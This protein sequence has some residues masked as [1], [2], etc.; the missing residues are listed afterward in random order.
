MAESIGE[1]VAKALYGV[2]SS[3]NESDSN[4][5]AANV[6]DAIF[7]LGRCA[8]KVAVAITPDD[9]SPGLGATGGRVGS[10]TEAAMDIAG[11]LVRI[12][13]AIEHLAFEV[14]VHS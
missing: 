14:Q 8:K 10:L 11:A 6:V 12:A 4:F 7:F 13:D 2:L 3:P 1:R 9:A 5:E